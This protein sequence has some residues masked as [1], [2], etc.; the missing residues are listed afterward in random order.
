MANC[1]EQRILT[2]VMDAIDDYASIESITD[3]DIDNIIDS[4]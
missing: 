1:F 2:L 4:V 3:V